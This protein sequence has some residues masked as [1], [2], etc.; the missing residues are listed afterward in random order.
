ME[1]AQIDALTELSDELTAEESYKI[2]NILGIPEA[3]L[4]NVCQG[5]NFLFA[6]KYWSD[7]N[8][9]LFYLTLQDIRPDL[10]QVA[11]KIPWLCV[12]SPKN[13]KSQEIKFSVKTLINLLKTEITKDK[14]FMIYISVANEPKEIVDFGVTLN[15]LLEKGYVQKNLGKFSEILRGIKREDLL[16]KM[17]VYKTK[18]SE[19]TDE[20]FKIE[21]KREIGN[22][23]NEVERWKYNLKEYSQIRHGKVKQLL[24]DD[25][26]VDLTQIYVNLC[27]LSKNQVQ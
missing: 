14:W 6:I 18:F 16:E 2:K 25:E 26:S 15:I 5:I 20:E 3:L 1:I 19:M 7:H 10:S 24:E 8:P 11:C 23:A 13:C 27:I 22:Q 4:E 21:F 9:Y 12:S 17:K